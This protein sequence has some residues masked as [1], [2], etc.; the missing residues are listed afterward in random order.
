MKTA[1]HE[2][3]A[4]LP[5]HERYPYGVFKVGDKVHRNFYS[6]ISPATVIEVK[7][8]GREVTIRYDKFD[9]KEGQKPNFIK[10]GFAGHCT[11]QSELEY[12]ISK[13][14]KGEVTTYTLRKWRGRYVWTAKGTNPD[15][16]MEIAQGWKAF[17]DYNF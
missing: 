5:Q 11:N 4:N 17:H 7:R 15:G 6:D 12:E 16:R 8:N 9:L 14:A 10:G 1:Q 3:I 13:D 2:T